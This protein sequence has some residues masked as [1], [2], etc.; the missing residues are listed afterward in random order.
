M[1][2]CVC[3]AVT[4]RQVRDCVEHGANT[5]DQVSFN[6]GLGFGCGRCREFASDLLQD[7]H[8]REESTAKA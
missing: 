2:V 5:L 8:C 6:T 7:L 4:E 1:Y 3:N